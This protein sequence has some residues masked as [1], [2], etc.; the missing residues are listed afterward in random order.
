MKTEAKQHKTFK[1]MILIAMEITD[2]IVK[3]K[4]EPISKD[5]PK[6]EYDIAYAAMV[7]EGNEQQE[8][9]KHCIKKKSPVGQAQVLNATNREFDV[10]DIK[11]AANGKY[12]IRYSNGG[13]RGFRMTLLI[14][15]FCNTVVLKNDEPEE[16]IKPEEEPINISQQSEVLN[17]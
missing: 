7:K 5:L 6:A 3:K 1:Q 16:E 15:D 12:Y 8:Y 9:I 2:P 14:S 11:I 10:C 17:A 13:T 4:I